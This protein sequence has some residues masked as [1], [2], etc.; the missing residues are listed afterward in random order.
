MAKV[1]GSLCICQYPGICSICGLRLFLDQFKNTCRTG[2]CTLQLCHDTGN[3]VKRLGILVCIRKQAGKLS[4]CQSAGDCRH[5]ARQSNS[6]INQTVDKSRAG[7]GNGR[8]E[9]CPQG[10]LFQPSVDFI[11]SFQC[12]ILSVKGLDHLLITYH[13]IDQVGLFSSCF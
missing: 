1:N 11:K 4:Y 2:K 7:I 10:I 5:G 3:F 13:F 12:F 8:K 9:D 6:H